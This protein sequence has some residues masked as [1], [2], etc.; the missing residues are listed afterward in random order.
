MGFT[1][2]FLSADPTDASRLR[3]GEELR[4]IQEKLQMAKHRELF[5]LHQRM[6]VRSADISQALLDV[7]PEIV[8]FSGHG[9]YTGALCFENQAGEIQMVTPEALSA[10]FEQFSDQVKCV[11]LNA[12]YSEDQVKL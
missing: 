9:T 7:Q 10:L 11:L 5:K 3:L 2:L 1:I 4:E 12:C 8:H 6:S